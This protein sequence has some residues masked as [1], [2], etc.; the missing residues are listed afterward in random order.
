MSEAD[1]RKIYTIGHGNASV[2][3]IIQLLNQYRIQE[4][5]DVRSVPYSQ[6]TPHF[7][8]ATLED[9]L[10]K[11]QINY[12]FAGEHLGG[13][14]DDP[15]CYKDGKLP[16]K[17]IDK[18]DYLKLVDYDEVA[19]R[20]FYLKGLARLIDLAGERRVAIMCSEEDPNMCHRSRLIAYSLIERGVTVRHIRKDGRLEDQKDK[21]AKQL[22]IFS[23]L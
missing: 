17:D 2:E 5:V 23:L 9:T 11:A 22:D 21:P 10:R 15:T 13:R 18:E 8:R 19:K 7:N 20:P 14:P 1:R 16:D 4:L 12:R 3:T 6:Y